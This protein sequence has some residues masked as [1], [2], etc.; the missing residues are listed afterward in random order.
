MSSPAPKH[1]TLS[2]PLTCDAV[3]IYGAS[4]CKPC[5]WAE[6]HLARR[7]VHNV[8]ERDVEND[9][10]AARFVRGSRKPGRST[11]SIPVIDV[12]GSLVHGYDP[13]AIDR[14]LT[15]PRYKSEG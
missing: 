12:C 8:V 15:R 7:G 9:D 2:A 10:E 13:D 6:Q 3:T 14:A 4:W 11:T 1:A 5:V